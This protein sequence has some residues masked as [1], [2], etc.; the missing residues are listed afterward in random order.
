MSRMMFVGDSH[1]DLN[2]LEIMVDKAVRTDC[3]IIF[4]LGDFGYWEH[5]SSGVAY[6]NALQRVLNEAD[7]AFYFLDGNHDNH[8]LLWSKYTDVDDEGFVIVRPNI[9]YSPRGHRWRWNNTSFLSL[10]GAYSID[11]DWRVEQY[12]DVL[13]AF[14]DG[15][16]TR[17]E[18]LRESA[19]YEAWW[20]TEM[21]TPDQ[22]E[23][24]IKGGK[25]DI[26]LSHDVG[27]DVDMNAVMIS[28]GRGNIKT[29]PNSWDNRK[30]L[31]EVI[32]AVRPDTV[33]HGH[34]HVDYR[35][36][37][38]GTRYAGYDCNMHP[39]GAWGIHVFD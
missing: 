31:Q 18:A 9:F 24:S 38:G 11:K 10:G 20:D 34:W 8:P 22:M 25:V 23:T 1:G 4:Q 19:K 35:T 17:A 32:N 28:H 15:G 13:H 2:F 37:E 26:L 29:D 7:K 27:T 30:R 39:S 33:H 12:D 36:K 3:K 6:L 5:T 21:I 16:Y 14:I